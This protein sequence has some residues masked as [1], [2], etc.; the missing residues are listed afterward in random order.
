[1]DWLVSL[2]AH[3]LIWCDER[4]LRL[5]GDATVAWV[6]LTRTRSITLVRLVGGV[7]VAGGVIAL[8][9][10]VLERRGMS[11]ALVLVTIGVTISTVERAAN[12]TLRPTLPP[13]INALTALI[14]LALLGLG[15]VGLATMLVTGFSW[16]EVGYDVGALAYVVAVYLAR[17]PPLDPPPPHERRV[18]AGA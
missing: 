16:A 3:A 1:M 14:S 17:I 9:S 10:A 11:V 12:T 7:G 8:V 15:S 13:P 2:L 18:L 4:W 5:A 6:R